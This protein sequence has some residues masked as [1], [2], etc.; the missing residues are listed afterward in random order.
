[1]GNELQ[2]ISFNGALLERGFW[3][4]VWESTTGSGEKVYYAGRTGDSSSC[5]AQSP[6]NRLSQ[7]LGTNENQNTFRT[8]LKK[9][10]IIPEDCHLEMVAYGPIL[11]EADCL[12]DHR[13]TQFTLISGFESHHSIMKGARYA[14]GLT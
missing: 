13:L 6:F 10:A 14:E 4:Y 2:Q 7:H 12:G 8:Q 5:N 3:L 11:P 9:A 1:M